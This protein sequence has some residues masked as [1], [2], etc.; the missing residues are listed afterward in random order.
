MDTQQFEEAELDYLQQS[1]THHSISSFGRA[2][3]PNASPLYA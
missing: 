3:A 2:D 1:F